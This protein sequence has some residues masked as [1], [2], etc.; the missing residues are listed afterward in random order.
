MRKTLILFF[1][2]VFCVVFPPSL[3]ALGQAPPESQERWAKEDRAAQA[4]ETLR[5]T[6][7]DRDF[8]G[9]FHGVSEDYRQ[10][11]TDLRSDLADERSSIS[12]VDMRFTA[13]QTVVEGD[14]AAIQVRWKKRTMDARTGQP[15]LSE[16]SAEFVFQFT[17]D[18]KT[19]LLDIRGQSPF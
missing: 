19:L 6:Y 13:S 14:K 8:A 10:G 5:R 2:V 12:A 1:A 7:E 4:L 17:A 15:A 16:G 18:E 11:E 9:F 3:L